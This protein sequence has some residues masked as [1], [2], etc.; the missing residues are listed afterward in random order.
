M[1]NYEIPDGRSPGSNQPEI[2]VAHKTI[3]ALGMP[4]V[5]YDGL[6]QLLTETGIPYDEKTKILL[7]GKG[8]FGAYYGL[9]L[10]VP[11]SFRI[12]APTSERKF[13]SSGG[14]VRVIAHEASH[15][16]DTFQNSRIRK[17]AEFL[18]TVAAF[19]LGF[20]AGT[21][22]E[23]SGPATEIGLSIAAYGFYYSKLAPEEKRAQSH[24]TPDSIL[25]HE[26][27]I[28]FPKSYRTQVSIARAKGSTETPFE[29]DTQ[30]RLE[31]VHLPPKI[32]GN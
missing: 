27:D 23:V 32:P 11:G 12:N 16:A 20:A 9:H 8:E 22:A 7:T 19:G 18:G 29:E 6:H 17:S 13:Y 4:A 5:N 26:T 28:L 31:K 15:R 3:D 24:E 2:A 25:P 30:I 21:T 10:S 1:R 14:V